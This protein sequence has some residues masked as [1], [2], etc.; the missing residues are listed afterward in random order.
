[1]FVIL[2]F[3]PDGATIAGL[4]PCAFLV[5][6]PAKTQILDQVKTNSTSQLFKFF[7]KLLKCFSGIITS[8]F[9]NESIFSSVFPTMFVFYLKDSESE[10]SGLLGSSL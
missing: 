1:M 6:I 4:S 8:A 5:V 3:A 10:E 7:Q 2:N 9:V